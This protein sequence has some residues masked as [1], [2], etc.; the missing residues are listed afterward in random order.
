V[1]YPNGM[2]A[3]VVAV[4]ALAACSNQR[5]PPIGDP[6]AAIPQYTDDA[7]V[8]PVRLDAGNDGGTLEILDF[9]G[10]CTSGEIPVWRYFDFQTTTPGDSSLLMSARTADAEAGLD[11]AQSVVLA[12]VSGPDITTWTGVDVDPAL[13]SIGDHSRLFLRVSILSTPASDG[14][15]PALVHYRQQYDCVVG[16]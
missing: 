7:F 6:D 10:V 2:R 12:N 4:A 9:E 8:P 16:Q 1:I 13:A 11:G 14:T 15:Q 5:P 3:L